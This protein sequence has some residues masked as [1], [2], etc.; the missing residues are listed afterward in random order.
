MFT[1]ASCTIEACRSGQLD[2]MPKNC[3][4]RDRAFFDS[5]L[6]EYFKPENHD[7]FIA[8]AATEAI[9]YCRWPRLRE[10]VEFSKRMGYTRLGLAFCAGLH[11]E[12]EVV[13]RVLRQNG[14]QVASVICKTGSIPKDRAGVPPE[15]RVRPGT[16]EVMCN[17]IAQA[18]LL[19]RVETQFNICLGLCVGHDSLFYRY[20]Q[21][22]VTTL[23]AKDRA[24]GN[25]PVAAIY[26]ADS[27]F[28]TRPDADQP[29][30]HPAKN[31]AC[32]TVADG[33]SA[34]R[35]S[36][37]DRLIFLRLDF[38]YRLSSAS[39]IRSRARSSS[40]RIWFW[41]SWIWFSSPRSAA[42]QPS[43]QQGRP[44]GGIWT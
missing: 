22:P 16:Y 8:S 6:E 15:Y 18:E 39:A 9:G 42:R 23:V 40:A 12:A 3:P 41:W 32:H 44:S 5:I 26:C 27:Y 33:I 37:F 11:R 43:G 19:N 30:P 14:F 31:P 25:N 38:G 13:D 17:P 7:F 28:K 2:K 20:S 21:A 24:T 1:C 34:C 29:S 36:L 10:V 4:M 35:K